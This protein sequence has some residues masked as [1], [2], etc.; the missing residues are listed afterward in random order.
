MSSAEDDVKSNSLNIVYSDYDSNIVNDFGN[1]TS[2]NDKQ[3]NTV[4]PPGKFYRQT[5]IND[6]SGRGS[7]RSSIL[8]KIEK[9]SNSTRSHQKSLSDTPF[10]KST[11]KSD[12]NKTDEFTKRKKISVDINQLDDVI[13][14]TSTK[15]QS[16]IFKSIG[17][18]FRGSTRSQGSFAYKFKTDE[19]E[20]TL[21]S[22]QQSQV[23]AT[24]F[25]SNVPKF[26]PVPVVG[27]A[28]ATFEEDFR[29]LRISPKRRR[30]KKLKSPLEFDHVW[31]I[32][33]SS[34][35]DTSYSENS[36]DYDV[37]THCS[38]NIQYKL[39]R[40]VEV[41]YE[42]RCNGNNLLLKNVVRY[43][44]KYPGFSVNNKSLDDHLVADALIIPGNSFGF[45]DGE[46]EIKY[47][48]MFGWELQERLRRKIKHDHDGELLIGQCI[49]LKINEDNTS[50][51]KVKKDENDILQITKLDDSISNESLETQKSGDNTDHTSNECKDHTT[52][53]KN[54][55]GSKTVETDHFDAAITEMN[56][57]FSCKKADE[58]HE[59][60]E[61]LDCVS[62]IEQCEVADTETDVTHNG[63]FN[64][65]G[66]TGSEKDLNLSLFSKSNANENHG[67]IS[68]KKMEASSANSESV[69]ST[70]SG[71]N[72][73][74]ENNLFSTRSKLR[75]PS[76]INFDLLE[77]TEKLTEKPTTSKIKY[78]IYVPVMRVPSL[79]QDTVNCYLAF[80]SA[81]LAVK[82]H[83]K[84]NV[85]IKSVILPPLCDGI[86]NMP[87]GRIAFQ[88]KL[89]YQEFA[90]NTK[91]QSEDDDYDAI[92]EE[93][94][95]LGKLAT[96][97]VQMCSIKNGS[98]C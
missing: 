32:E 15:T 17:S 56:N 2:S 31:D 28:F 26:N 1:E 92:I 49:I 80:R 78:I 74:S 86:C 93:S 11:S 50:Q 34:D 43:L 98:W 81:L 25:S 39:Q 58:N 12:I 4:F 55:E 64:C 21:E 57:L 16:S 61:T 54:F 27:T 90:F 75:K 23:S 84:G 60:T 76:M 38:E 66:N 65:K 88:I 53:T 62:E 9:S 42:M 3:N 69:I 72:E 5:S 36:Q 70:D 22:E 41:S 97:H 82:K 19:K 63:N 95:D 37:S 52:N 89:A 33:T 94:Q 7:I 13:S 85:P 30:R 29:H 71:I 51:N 48:D 10:M 40:K 46:P 96:K 59:R 35:S 47:V 14:L 68:D 91:V 8:S 6:L 67:E 45:L 18:W 44:K 83:N 24:T 77:A 73:V 20:S 87:P 79:I